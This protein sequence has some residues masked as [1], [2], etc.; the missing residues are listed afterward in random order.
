MRYAKAPL[1][2]GAEQPYFAK[3]SKGSTSPFI[4]KF[5]SYGFCGDVEKEYQINSFLEIVN[6][7]HYNQLWN[8]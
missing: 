1:A 8:E 3:A 5:K 2:P 6:L 7:V 4:P